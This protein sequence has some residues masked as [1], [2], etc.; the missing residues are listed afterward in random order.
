[1]TRPSVVPHLA[2]TTPAP[3]PPGP[4]TDGCLVSARV[5]RLTASGNTMTGSEKVLVEDWCQQFPSHSVG[6]LLF[7][8]DG[9]L[10]VGGGDGASFNNV[11]YGQYGAT[12]AGDKANPCADPPSPA[13]TAL[14]SADRRGRCAA[15]P[16]R[17]AHRRP[18]HPGRGYPADR[19]RHRSGLAR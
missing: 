9:K 5:S 14:D 11:D 2:G 15:Q 12:Y 7:G 6:T 3:T 18:R 13:G 4:T 10:Y 19:P 1:M 17:P 8:R 16:E